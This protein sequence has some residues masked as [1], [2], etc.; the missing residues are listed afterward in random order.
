MQTTKYLHSCLLVEEQNK[1]ILIDPGVFTYNEH[2]LDINKL[3]K[4]DYI[5]ITHEHADHFYLPFIKDLV[6][7]FPDVKIITNNS[8]VALLQRENIKAT[9]ESDEVVKIEISPHERLWDVEAPENITVSIFDK[10]T[11]VGDS[12]CFIKSCGILA[13]PITAPWGSTT[14][15]VNKALEIRPKVI[16]PIHDWMW[17]DEVRMG[18][19]QRLKDFFATKEIDF[20]TPETGEIV[21]I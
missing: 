8:I 5:A 7:K 6:Q 13:L 18:M 17:K 11:H 9:S 19:Y 1:T 2:A 20:K 15:A 16:I 12:I 21:E 3:N 14:D 4:L 10:L